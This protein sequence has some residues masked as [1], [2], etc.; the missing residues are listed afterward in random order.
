MVN[1]MYVQRFVE[2]VP[3]VNLRPYLR[4]KESN[5]IIGLLRIRTGQGQF[6]GESRFC[7]S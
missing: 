4:C 5:T 1:K 6:V 2:G 3:G 7:P